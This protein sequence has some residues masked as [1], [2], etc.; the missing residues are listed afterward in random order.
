MLD[1]RYGTA[2]SGAAE[3]MREV[4]KLHRARERKVEAD[5]AALPA[6]QEELELA[7]VLLGFLCEKDNLHKDGFFLKFFKGKTN[8]DIEKVWPIVEKAVE[9]YHQKVVR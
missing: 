5:A 7:L 4:Q 6:V 1:D 8:I 2:G 3:E 9:M